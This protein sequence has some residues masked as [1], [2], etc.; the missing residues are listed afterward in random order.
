MP[1]P[2]GG[3]RPATVGASTALRTS[4]AYPQRHVSLWIEQDKD[5]LR[6]T[7]PKNTG[8]Y[9][10]RQRMTGHSPLLRARARAHLMNELQDLFQPFRDVRHAF[11]PVAKNVIVHRH[12]EHRRIPRFRQEYVAV[13]AVQPESASVEI[14]RKESEVLIHP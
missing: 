8:I 9:P 10:L 7:P 14:E 4:Q 3:G 6:A 12:P 1:L 11:R 13:R 2:V 5:A